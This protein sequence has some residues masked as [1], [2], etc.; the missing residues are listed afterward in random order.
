VDEP[1]GRLDSAGAL[2]GVVRDGSLV[3]RLE[4]WA[5]EA[6]VDD[7]ARARARERWLR[8]QAAEEGT[9]GGVLVDLL[10]AG[11]PVTVHTRSGAR[12]VATVRAVGAD[13]VALAPGGPGAPGGRAE[14]VLV[15]LAAVT[16]VR[17]R[18]GA[19]PLVG[20]RPPAAGV[21]L[22]DVVAGLAAER[23]QVRIAAVDGDAVTGV[24]QSVGLDVAVVR[25]VGDPPAMA[26]VPLAA[27]AE[28]VVPA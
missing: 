2:D 8:V 24:V 15:A 28:I 13:F 26:Y 18:P 4:R 17:S 1:P 19:R 16:S 20:D 7:A 11:A 3:G 6:R 12:H 22:A 9:F 21:H 27:I 5:A 25:G 10:E 23:E 14:E